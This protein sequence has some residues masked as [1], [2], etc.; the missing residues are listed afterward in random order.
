MG[1]DQ[2]KNI[3]FPTEDEMGLNSPICH[4]FGK[5]PYL[6]LLKVED[7]IIMD[8]KVFETQGRHAGGHTTAAEVVLIN[9]GDVVICGN[10]GGKAVEMLGNGGVQV[11]SGAN[12]TVSQAFQQWKNEDLKPGSLKPC[13]EGHH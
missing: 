8:L 13:T 1:D 5:T 10:L 12:G 4:H 3:L 6:T 2:I 11:F 7:D 9:D